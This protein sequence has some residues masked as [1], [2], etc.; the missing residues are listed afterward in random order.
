VLLPVLLLAFPG[1]VRGVLTPGTYHRGGRLP[2]LGVLSLAAR[3]GRWA[4]RGVRIG[5]ILAVRLVL[6]PVKAL[7]VLGAVLSDPALRALEQMGCD[8]AALPGDTCAPSS[9]RHLVVAF[10]M[11]T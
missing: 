4:R 8:R 9:F 7:A 5:H 11:T 1:T 2:D 3:L 10:A 6:R